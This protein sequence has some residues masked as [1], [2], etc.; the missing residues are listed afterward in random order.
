MNNVYFIG[1]GEL[2]FELIERIINDNMKLELAP[3][4]KELSLIHI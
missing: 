2:T 1:S 3:E 4:A